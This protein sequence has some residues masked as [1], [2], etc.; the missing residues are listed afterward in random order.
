M[1]TL[2]TFFPNPA[3]QQL[4]LDGTAEDLY[5]QLRASDSTEDMF[6]AVGAAYDLMECQPEKAAS[7]LRLAAAENPAQ[8]EVAIGA[9]LSLR[10]FMDCP[11]GE[12]D[13]RFVALC[14]ANGLPSL[15]SPQDLS[16]EYVLRAM[17][18]GKK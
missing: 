14:R 7:L 6:L 18:G 8:A 10:E 12:Q 11:L 3:E 16:A 15:G 1:T 13:E 9:A 17:L 5:P 2:G 4:L